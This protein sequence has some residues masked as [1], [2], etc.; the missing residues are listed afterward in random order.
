MNG[1]KEKN[2]TAYREV[3]KINYCEP[4]GLCCY[5]CGLLKKTGLVFVKGPTIYFVVV[6]FVLLNLSSVLF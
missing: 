6:G 5:A 3:I 2:C 4:L 1:G